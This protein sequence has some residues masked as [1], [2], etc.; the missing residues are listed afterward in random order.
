MNEMKLAIR[1]DLE[2]RIEEVE[3]DKKFTFELKKAKAAYKEK[4]AE[5]K[6]AKRAKKAALKK[7][8]A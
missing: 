5:K 8:K 4:K 1:K 2:I 7:K 3:L 6:A